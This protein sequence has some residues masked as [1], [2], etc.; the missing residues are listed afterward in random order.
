MSGK[1]KSSDFVM[2]DFPAEIER[3]ISGQG[4]VSSRTI[5]DFLS[6]FSL[7]GEQLEALAETL[8]DRVIC[9]GNE[10]AIRRAVFK[11]R[12]A[13]GLTLKALA[14][15]SPFSCQRLE[16][17]EAG[18]FQNLSSAECNFFSDVFGFV[19]VPE[20]PQLY[21]EPDEDGILL[22]LNELAA[23]DGASDFCAFAEK[24]CVREFDRKE[25]AGLNGV[26]VSGS[27]REIGFPGNGEVLMKV[28]DM[29]Q[30]DFRAEA[31][32]LI[33]GA[34]GTFRIASR[35]DDRRITLDGRILDEKSFCWELQIK[36]L[37]YQDGRLFSLEDEY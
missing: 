14:I 30:R 9:D 3:V 15:S 32:V 16:D 33:K 1:E 36:K 26:V 23:Y 34:D 19:C 25:F 4:R 35:K 18:N 8:F 2:P 22:T 37:I 10:K 17:I 12:V 28:A 5:D 27:S 24:A 20:T 21:S 6:R 29:P 31:A 7:S 11:T 13:R